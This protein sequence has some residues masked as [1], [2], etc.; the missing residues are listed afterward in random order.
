M[1]GNE[2]RYI[3]DLTRPYNNLLATEGSQNQSFV[4]G[5]ELLMAEGEKPFG[6]LQDHLGSPVRLVGAD[7]D[8]ALAFDEFG[9]AVVQV[10]QNE[11]KFN[12][13][14]GFTGYQTDEV[15]GLYYAQARYFDPATSRFIS[16]DYVRD[17]V[18][19]YVHCYNNPLVFVDL[20]GWKAY[21]VHELGDRYKGQYT[22][23]VTPQW[24]DATQSAIGMAPVVG[25]I[26]SGANWGVQRLAGF[27]EINND[28]TGL[29]SFITGG[30]QVVDN[31]IIKTMSKWAGRALSAI[32]AAKYAY[33]W[34]YKN[35]YKIEE[36]IYNHFDYST[37]ISSSRDIVDA[38]F[39]DAFSWIAEQI[40]K[41][42][43]DIK[44]AIDVFGKDAFRNFGGALGMA[45]WQYDPLTKRFKIF[46]QNEYY[47][48][49]LDDSMEGYLNTLENALKELHDRCP[50]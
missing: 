20:D 41:G 22:L 33:D 32:E 39:R 14:F 43:L 17:G 6:Y 45:T 13:P 47:L 15:S 50:A 9:V 10:G 42:N 1:T 27:K 28:A 38:K 49:M 16:E 31:D 36:V 11:A 34:F 3:L 21:S 44:K 48:F 26:I 18:N 30:G 23:H 24:L 8:E 37:W 40:A 19:W 5:N 35:N 2:M 7:V 12:Q 46:R 29:L 4:W 25:F